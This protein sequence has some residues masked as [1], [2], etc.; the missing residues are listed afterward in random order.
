MKNNQEIEITESV[1]NAETPEQAAEI[2]KWQKDY[3]NGFISC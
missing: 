2:E 3:S 1:K